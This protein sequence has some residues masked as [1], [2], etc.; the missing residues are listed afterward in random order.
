M[1]PHYHLI[2]NVI[3]YLKVC[4]FQ[5]HLIIRRKKENKKEGSDTLELDIPLLVKNN[6]ISF[7]GTNDKEAALAQAESRDIVG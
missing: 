6:F 2:Q 4:K 3:G 7:S 5:S 1:V